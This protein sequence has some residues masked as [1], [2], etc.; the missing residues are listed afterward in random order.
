[1]QGIVNTS[2]QDSLQPGRPEHTE[3]QQEEQHQ[4][5][6]S[7]T[8][9]GSSRVCTARKKVGVEWQGKKGKEIRRSGKDGRKGEKLQVDAPPRRLM[10]NAR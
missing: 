3:T 1:M 5:E 2:T 9:P 10:G 6:P 8:T 7:L 4:P